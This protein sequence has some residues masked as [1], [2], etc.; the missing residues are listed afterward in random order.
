M[1]IIDAHVH[2]REAGTPEFNET[3]PI[4]SA[5]SAAVYMM[6]FPKPL[7]LQNLSDAVWF[8][9]NYHTAIMD[10]AGKAGNPNHYAMLMPVLAENMEPVQLRQFIK[11]M[12]GIGGVP[13]A[14]FKLFPKGQ[15]TNSGYAPSLEKAC[16][17]IDVLEEM[18]VPLALHME[19]PDEPNVSKKEQSAMENILPKL[20]NRGRWPSDINI[21]IEHISKTYGLIM[22]LENNL[23]CTITPHHLGLCQEDFNIDDP[24]NAEN[25]LSTTE[26]YFYCKPIIQAR[27]SQRFLHNFWLQGEYDRLMP[28]TD[29]AP[30]SILKKDSES[31]P[32]GIFMGGTVW[33]YERLLRDQNVS[34]LLE[35][36]SRNAAQFYGIEM[37][38]LP[39]AEVPNETWLH[40]VRNMRHAAKQKI[41][42]RE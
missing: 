14:G 16:T 13:L 24:R 36:Y 39:D 33:A 26:P 17:L 2:A 25:I 27:G 31:P 15:S 18:K 37:A 19:D 28:G 9:R 32:A 41:K 38:G 29:S 20:I 7:D 10:A 11:M 42:S 12:K 23:W 1:K 22:A 3:V 8:M 4:Y 6:N 21:S 34:A 5:N 30:H 35:R 40:N